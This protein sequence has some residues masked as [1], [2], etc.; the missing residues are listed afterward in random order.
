M[1]AGALLEL[2]MCFFQFYF[3]FWRP[4]LKMSVKAPN[5]HASKVQQPGLQDTAVPSVFA[6]IEPLCTILVAWTGSCMQVIVAWTSSQQQ[7]WVLH[8]CAFGF[9]AQKH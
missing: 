5:G 4:K 7:K 2:Y 8:A 1:G 9:E 3:S 6:A